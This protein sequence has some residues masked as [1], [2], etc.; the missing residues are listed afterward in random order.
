M[1]SIGESS[2][3]DN[4]DN[5]YI[6]TNDIKDIW[7]G[8]YVHPNINSIYA[9]L[10]IRDRTRQAQSHW[11]GAELSEKYG[12]RFK[13]VFSYYSYWT[14]FIFRMH[15]HNEAVAFHTMNRG[16]RDTRLYPYLVKFAHFYPFLL[17]HLRGSSVLTPP[18]PPLFLHPVLA[19]RRRFCYIPC[20]C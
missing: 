7:G 2:A 14:V 12:Q 20:P 1:D 19:C 6:S 13:L 8:K 4:S 15:A 17:S 10:K 9:R 5:K 18:P 11:K 16:Q 3:D